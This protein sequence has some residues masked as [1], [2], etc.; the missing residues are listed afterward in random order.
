MIKGALVVMKVTILL[1]LCGCDMGGGKDSI[2]FQN[3]LYYF[4]DESCSIPKKYIYLYP[5]L[6]KLV[7]YILILKNTSWVTMSGLQFVM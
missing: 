6:Y 1:Q 4:S 7:C 5:F 2:T 3:N